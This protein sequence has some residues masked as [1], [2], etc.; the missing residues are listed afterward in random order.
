MAHKFEAGISE[1]VAHI[2]P[3]AGTEIVDT[4]HVMAAR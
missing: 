2:V 4:Q 3:S 1:K